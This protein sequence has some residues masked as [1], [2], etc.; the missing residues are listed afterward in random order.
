MIWFTADTHFGHTNILKPCDRPWDSVDEHDSGL[1]ANWNGRVDP[2]D[3]VYHLED[4]CWKQVEQY[5]PQTAVALGYPGLAR[6]RLLGL[7]GSGASR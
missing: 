3:K 5:L 1:I 4:F 2:K 6:F 7:S